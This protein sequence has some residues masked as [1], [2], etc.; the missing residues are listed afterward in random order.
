[1]EIINLDDFRGKKS[2]ILSG[3]DEGEAARVKLKME[4]LDISVNQVKIIVP[5]DIW[6]I[7][8]S[9]FLGLFGESIRKMGEDGFREKFIF[10]CSESVSEDVEE[11]IKYALKRYSALKDGS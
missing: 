2:K 9:F 4:K 10:E 11:S 3:R 6:S 1:M 7:N 5:D 8:S